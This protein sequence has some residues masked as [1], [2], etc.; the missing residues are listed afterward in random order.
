MPLLD[1]KYENCQTFQCLHT[2][3]LR[4]YYSSYFLCNGNHYKANTHHRCLCWITNMKIFN[5]SMSPRTHPP[6]IL[7]FVDSSYFLCNGNHYKANSHHRCPCWTT[8]MKIV[9]R[10]NVSSHTS[11]VYIILCRFFLFLMQ[12][13]SLQS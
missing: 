2:Y 12:W 10:F 3:I 5:V 13:K 8:N 6:Y 1:N 9:K 11:P 4:L 7:F